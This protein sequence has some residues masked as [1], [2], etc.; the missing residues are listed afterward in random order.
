MNIILTALA[1]RLV[2]MCVLSCPMCNTV[3][4]LVLSLELRCT[5]L[6]KS[7]SL[8]QRTFSSLIHSQSSYTQLV[9]FCSVT[10][11]SKP[12]AQNKTQD[13]EKDGDSDHT[14]GQTFTSYSS[15]TSGFIASGTQLTLFNP[16]FLTC[17]K[18]RADLH[19]FQM[20]RCLSEEKRADS[21]QIFFL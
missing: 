15:L 16:Q 19:Y 2:S 20:S 9:N 14:L 18:R 12:I 5:K 17:R 11:D 4:S 6:D 21:S 3:F 10:N 7:S 8:V 13:P 1:A